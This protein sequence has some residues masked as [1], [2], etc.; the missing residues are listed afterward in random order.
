MNGG[1]GNQ[2]NPRDGVAVLGKTGSHEL[3]QTWMVESSTKVAT[4]VWAGNANGE[5]NPFRNFYRGRALSDI[6]YPIA[7]AV[8]SVANDVYGGERAF[9]Q[10]ASNLTRQVTR[11]VP[12]VVGQSIEQA[13][14]T[15]Q[16]AGWEVV[17]GDPVDSAQPTRSEERRVGKELDSTCKSRWSPEHKKKKQTKK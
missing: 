7:R 6:R 3:T 2:A 13:Q 8:Q 5:L 11:D 4:A 9:P 14:A 12:N 16:D 17:V 1:T 10:P 15:L